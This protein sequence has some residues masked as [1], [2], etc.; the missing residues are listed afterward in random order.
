MLA[1][2]PPSVAHPTCPLG[3]PNRAWAAHHFCLSA[4]LSASLPGA[5]PVCPLPHPSG[6][7]ENWEEE[8]FSPCSFW[9]H[10]I[11]LPLIPDSSG[12]EGTSYLQNFRMRSRRPFIHFHML[13]TLESPGAVLSVF[14]SHSSSIEDLPVPHFRGY[15]GGLKEAG[16]LC[17][18]KFSQCIYL[19]LFRIRK[20]LAYRRASPSFFSKGEGRASRHRHHPPH[21][22]LLLPS[23]QQEWGGR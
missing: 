11:T 18:G 15:P 13:Q 23:P 12:V 9:A 20:V 21:C 22:P 3:W 8:E 2:S 1:V 17:F 19:T 4:K 5:V 10:D 7:Y 14:C 6:L 16:L